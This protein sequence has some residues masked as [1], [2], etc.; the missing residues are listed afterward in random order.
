MELGI[1]V[2][3]C[4]FLG[5]VECGEAGVREIPDMCT[6]GRITH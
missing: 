3:Y 1:S 4:C 2:V 6:T 5:G